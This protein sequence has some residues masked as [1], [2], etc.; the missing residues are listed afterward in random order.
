MGI[1]IEEIR[2]SFDVFTLGK[3]L[4]SMV[5]GQPKLQLWYFDKPQFNVQK[6]FPETPF[7]EF[8]NPIL[9]K[10]VVEN[11]D[12]CL[13][14]A[15]LLLKEIDNVLSQISVNADIISPT[16]QRKCKVCGLGNYSLIVDRNGIDLQNFGITAAGNR[17]MKVF[18]CEHCGHVQLFAFGDGRN[19]KA[20]SEE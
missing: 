15:G 8:V 11:E 2:P 4:W 20:W 10:C 1:K 7:I 12:N 9:A 14:D 16:V 6:L 18:A 17:S 3:L 5:S 13:A 19:P